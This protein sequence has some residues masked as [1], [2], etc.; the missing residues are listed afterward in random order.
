[1]FPSAIIKKDKKKLQGAE[2]VKPTPFK[3]IEEVEYKPMEKTMKIEA[4]DLEVS[5]KVKPSEVPSAIKPKPEDLMT[6]DLMLK[7]AKK[8]RIEPPEGANAATSEGEYFKVEKGENP[9]EKEKY[10]KAIGKLK[11]KK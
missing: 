4:G 6:I 3:G 1:M 2:K 11:K 10:L 9:E 5:K 7:S 8:K